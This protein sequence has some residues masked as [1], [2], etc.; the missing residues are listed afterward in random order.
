M[1]KCLYSIEVFKIRPKQFFLENLTNFRKIVVL[2]VFFL[3]RKIIKNFFAQKID[4][5]YFI[6]CINLNTYLFCEEK[7]LFLSMNT[8]E[9]T[10]TFVRINQINLKHESS[11]V[12][13]WI[14]N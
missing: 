4:F 10:L 6:Y 14:I 2:G 5:Q 7:P 11:T 3:L 8:G 9:I 1:F 13:K 12:K